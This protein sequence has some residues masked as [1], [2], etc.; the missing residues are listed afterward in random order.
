MPLFRIEPLSWPAPVSED[1]DG[2]LITSANALRFGSKS[3]QTLVHLPVYAVGEA[4]AAEARKLGFNVAAAG[5]AGVETLLQSIPGKLQLLHPCGEDRMALGPIEHRV[6]QIAVYRSVK[7]PAP[8]GI[9][10]SEVVAVHS[11]R[12]ASRFAALATEAQVDRSRVSLAAISRATAEA[13]GHG[14]REVAV[15]ET[16]DDQCLLA[17]AKELCEKPGYK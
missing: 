2:L 8:V 12:A 5:S 7:L 11:P 14:W 4:S 1:F 15:A 9:G 16:P 17:L 3:L 6:T 13:A 10:L